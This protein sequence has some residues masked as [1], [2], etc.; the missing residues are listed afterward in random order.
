MNKE[1]RQNKYLIALLIPWKIIITN[2]AI[3][4]N[5]RDMKMM[6][7]RWFISLDLRRIFEGKYTAINAE[8]PAVT[9]KMA[10]II[11]SL[12]IIKHYSLLFLLLTTINTTIFSYFLDYDTA[13]TE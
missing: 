8:R 11:N 6:A 4:T 12:I 3:L 5:S 10:V 2:K 7:I 9:D 1:N 13:T